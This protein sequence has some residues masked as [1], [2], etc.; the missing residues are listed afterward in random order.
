MKILLALLFIS[1]TVMGEEVY[2]QRY[3]TNPVVPLRLQPPPYYTPE[4]L[5][6]ERVLEELEEAN[7]L[8]REQLELQRNEI[9]SGTDE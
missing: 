2:I 6:N 5:Q 9:E 8:A 7:E 1:S 4:R 3:D